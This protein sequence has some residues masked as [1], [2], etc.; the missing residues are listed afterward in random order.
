MENSEYK[1]KLRSRPFG[2]GTYPNNLD[3]GFIRFDD[4]G[5]YGTLVYSK[6]LSIKMIKDFELSPIT[7]ILK[8]DGAD[9]LWDDKY[10]TKVSV[11]KSD[12]GIYYVKLVMTHNGK[13]GKPMQE[14][15]VDFLTDVEKGRYKFKENTEMQTRTKPTI[16]SVREAFSKPEYTIEDVTPDGYGSDNETETTETMKTEK[17]IVESIIETE[18][19]KAPLEEIKIQNAEILDLSYQP[20]SDSCG[21][22]DTIV[23]A[24]MR[25]DM[26]KAIESV[27][28][29]V[30]GVDEYVAEKLGYIVGNCSMEERTTGLKCLC[31]SFSAEQVD[32][33]AVA[34]YNIEERGQGCIIGDQTGIGKGRIAG[35]MIR[36]AVK[37]GLKP[38]FLTEKPNLFSDLFRDIINIGSDDAIPL[39]ILTGYK[40]VKKKAVKVEVEVD[41]D[42]DEQDELEEEEEQTEY[43][44]VPVY[45]KNKDYPNSYTYVKADE[46]GVEKMYTRTRKNSMIPFIINGGGTKTAIKDEEGNVLYKGSDLLVTSSIG[47]R[48]K[49]KEV[50]GKTK[51]GAPKYAMKSESGAMDIPEGFDFVL[52]T[53][54]QFN[55]ATESP[56]MQYLLKIAQGNIV[57]MDESHNAS[58]DSF[59]GEFLRKVLDGTLGVTFLSATFSKRPD[60]MPIYAGKTAM[61]DANM[62]SEQ[63]VQAITLGGFA[64]QEIVSSNL[65]AEGQMIRRERSFEGIEVNYEYLDSSQTERGYPNLDLEQTHRA[66]MDNA[67]EIIRDIIN[68]QSDFVNPEVEAM[69]RIA[70]AEYKQVEQRKGTKSGGV[71]NQPV[72]SGV[73]NIINQLLFS[74]KA[75]SVGHV[76]IQRLKE[77]KKPV[78][79]FANTMESFLNSMTNDDG[80]LVKENDIVSSDF[81]KIFERR[82][83]SVLKYTIVNAEGDKEYESIDPNS[84]SPEFKY[85]Y[86][87][88][89]NKIKNA[90]L[91]ISSSP[92][93]VLINVIEKAGYSVAEVTG[94]DRQMKILGEGKGQIK[95]RSKLT[96]TDAFRKFNNNE[97][98]C[99]LINQS[100][101]TG[102]SAHALPNPKTPA[103]KVKQRV[104]II[105]QA[106][107]NI[108]T[109][110][111]KRGRINRTGQI[112]K[113]IY[114]YVISAIPSEKR[115]MMMLQKKLKSL[116]ANTTSNQK[117]SEE[118]LDARQVDFLNKYGDQIVVEYLKEHPLI[119]MQ[120]GDPLG[121]AELSGDETPKNIT[122]SAHKVSGRV[123]IL[124][125]KEQ[126][127]FYTELA[128]RYISLVEYLKQTQEYDLEVSSMN[129][130][131]ETLE[132]EIVVVGKGG[133][134]VF[135][136]HSILE[137]VRMN[138]LKKPYKKEEI[139]L[140]IK[141][142]LGDYTPEK[143]K[144][145]TIEKY[146]R[147]VKS[148][149]ENDIKDA[150]EH[151]ANL[152]SGI[153]K[154]KA[155]ATI[156]NAVERRDAIEKRK[157][158]IEKS[159][160]EYIERI[161]KT[162]ENKKEHISRVLS[163]FV[164]G[165]VVGYPTIMYKHDGSYDKAIFVG[166]VINENVKNPYTPSAM[167]M[168]FV[169]ASSQK[170]V[171]VPASKSDII[172]AV[173]TITIENIFSREKETTLENWDEIT[174]EKSAD[175]KVAYIVTGNILQAYGKEE[176]KGSLISYTTSTGGLKKGILLPDGFSKDAQGGRGGKEAMRI[177]VPIIKALPIIKSMMVGRSMTT[178]D[179]FSII[180]HE[181]FY[182]ISVPVNKQRGGK[183]YLDATIMK[184]TKEGT[185]NK[186]AD[187]MTATIEIK[188]IENLVEYLQDTFNNSVDLIQ[189]EFDRI[190]GDLVI[191]EYADEVRIPQPDVFIEK[192]TEVDKAGAEQELADKFNEEQQ[193]I[194]DA[195][196][197]AENDKK[198]GA[199]F[200]IE[201][202]KLVAK[203]KLI[204]LLRT[205]ANQ[206][207][208][209][210]K[211]G[212]TEE[213]GEVDITE[214]LKKFDTDLLDVFESIQFN[215]M[216]LKKTKKAEGKTLAEH[217]AETLQIIINNVEGDYSQ[218]SPELSKLAEK[219]N[220]DY[221]QEYKKGGNA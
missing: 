78:I 108:S 26:H 34:I 80:T 20:Q 113:P 88:I 164:V 4:D 74:I 165:R 93:D 155:I 146:E 69:D 63:L 143:L 219:Q 41:E 56:K 170:Y 207:L 18:E 79:A 190:K 100:G 161:R 163:W 98:D 14:S 209:M 3:L 194:A 76:A 144:E 60:N 214:D 126:E 96:T 175:K 171:G 213:S 152:V 22:V 5:G 90:S 68:F 6:P 55:S 8:Y 210:R 150:E 186:V 162:T 134:S 135:G 112:L 117:Q 185:F 216:Y 107:L 17:K 43:V 42:A 66:V 139:D 85:E 202:R 127:N 9:M 72:F 7:D 212:T 64:L 138:N 123:A 157:E 189:T 159:R 16:E 86:N 118:L 131:A 50:I 61:S 154:E 11:E 193:V 53:Y 99:L 133:E 205:F 199:E 75:E 28:R 92:L 45:E 31:D 124:S 211:G 197:Q 196:E 156:S 35:G 166:F 179:F 151:Y 10:D 188:K 27:D 208:I 192:L 141:E 84:M 2:V 30:N 217:K 147:F 104:M 167:K 137:K 173:K 65:V 218:L 187:K 38:I 1:Y 103:N 172:D 158:V 44:S 169:I 121:L 36:Y 115:L 62:T 33:I 184:L 182:R 105:L 70:K 148:N 195:L 206:E 116:D 32:A 40:Q 97:V 221:S 149:L 51:S 67:T 37:R 129:L 58:G 220:R 132:K 145:S 47:K 153:S 77:N 203:K 91:G 142:T 122:D 110:V 106:E 140:M 178:N 87:R 109:E 83:A 89:L 49:T 12:R 111:Q 200:L 174:K 29:R 82:L 94:R 25:Y 130:E 180:K 183:F 48:V 46:N 168:R 39:E 181:N 95:S 114:D 204:N 52:A 57:I 125:V 160:V 201:K 21:S 13:V 215:D 15:G 102:A 136:R 128:Q 119:N 177:S 54:S 81:S 191:E 73:F 176:L 23:P 71:D 59:V 19:N 101:S 198:Q 120:L 24:S